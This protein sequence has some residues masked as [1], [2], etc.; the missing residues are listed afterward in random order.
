MA[1]SAPPFPIE[2]TT[3][4]ALHA[5]YGVV[6]R[7]RYRLAKPTS[8]GSPRMTE[9]ARLSERSSSATL[10]RWRTRLCSMLPSRRR[11]RW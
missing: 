7:R 5:A 6:G 10:T 2:E 8:T 11:A 4:A 1:A 9:M 3:I